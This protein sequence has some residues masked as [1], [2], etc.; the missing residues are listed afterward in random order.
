VSFT[1]KHINSKS[2]FP[3]LQLKFKFF[4]YISLVAI[5][6]FLYLTT[7]K[8]IY[9]NWISLHQEYSR[10]NNNSMH[11]I[12]LNTVH[13]TLQ[14]RSDYC[15]KTLYWIY[16]R[17]PKT[18]RK[19]MI[20]RRCYH[21]KSK[22]KRMLELQ[23]ILTFVAWSLDGN[24]WGIWRSVALIVWR[25]GLHFEHTS[26]TLPRLGFHVVH[27]YSVFFKSVAA[28]AKTDSQSRS[29]VMNI[30]TSKSYTCY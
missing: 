4:T 14:H 2:I 17:S 5:I 10:K 21:I 20:R 16:L 29:V 24:S 30:S 27:R 19:R 22:K 25:W 23:R 18:K 7:S 9:K 3:Y 12:Y 13:Y 8:F 11:I 15:R 1:N 28:T 26:P 6:L